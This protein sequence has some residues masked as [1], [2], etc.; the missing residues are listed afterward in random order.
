MYTHTLP[1]RLV[2]ALFRPG[3]AVGAVLALTLI[4]GACEWS[5]SPVA[6]VG[7]PVIPPTQNVAPTVTVT[8]P[9]SAAVGVTRSIS[10]TATFSK[11]MNP[12]TI[13]GTTFTLTNGLVAVPAVVTYAA[14]VATLNPV[15]T[16]ASNTQYTAHIS[17]GARDMQG[18]SLASP[19]GW[20]FTTLLSSLTGPAAVDLH[21]AGNFVILAKS[22]VSTVGVTA[23]VGDVGLSPAAASFI[24]GFALSAPPTTFS[25]SAL[26]T[27][28]LF[29]SDYTPP[30]PTMLTTAILDMQNAFTDAAGRTLP[31]FVNLGAGNI[32]GMTLVPG[33]YKWGT[34]LQIPSA[35]TLSGGANDVWIFQIAQNLTVGNGAIVTLSGGAQ[36]KNVFWQVSGAATIGT[37]ANFKGNILSQTLISMNTGS[38][39]L[40]RALAQSAVTLNATSVTHP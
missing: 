39:L 4:A 30:T 18:D 31:D 11:A 16:L 13:N 6:P 9:V 14:S 27:G 5:N 29:A 22:G 26:V 3:L 40:G 17:Q 36:A 20:S 8:S 33:L 21:S 10:V 7:P 38:I 15:G 28:H 25:T 2:R 24:T 37:T 12:A 19:K 32:Q 23:I 35:V 34:G 1:V